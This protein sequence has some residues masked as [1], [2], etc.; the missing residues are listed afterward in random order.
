MNLLL[1]T[2]F[3]MSHI[4][5]QSSLVLSP[6]PCQVVDAFNLAPIRAL[7]LHGICHKEHNEKS[8]FD[9]QTENRFSSF[10][11]I[12]SLIFLEVKYFNGRFLNGW[13]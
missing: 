12:R 13:N 1:Q 6:T 3:D 7:T 5:L 10:I 2:F 11:Q 4:E 8:D 9:H